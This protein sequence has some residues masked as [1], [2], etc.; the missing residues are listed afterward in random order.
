MSKLLAYA[1]A[2]LLAVSLALGFGLWRSVS[3]NGTLRERADVAEK[4]LRTAQEAQK[5]TDR[6][7]AA[8]RAEKRAEVSKSALAA[9]ALKRAQEAAPEWSATPTP[10][11]VRE[12]L[13]GA[14]EGLQ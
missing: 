5:K 12:A 2:A 8:A 9:E 1:V 4:A 13:G 11:Q 10:P 14:L 7:L 6:L 3:A